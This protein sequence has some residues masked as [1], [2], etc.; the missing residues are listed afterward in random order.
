M[1]D[2]LNLSQF[3]EAESNEI[4][5]PAMVAAKAQFAIA[6]AGLHMAIEELELACERYSVIT[7]ASHVP[8]FSPRPI[9]SSH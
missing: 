1:Q 7:A 5:S 6:Q 3:L 2:T 9:T 4:H 8:L